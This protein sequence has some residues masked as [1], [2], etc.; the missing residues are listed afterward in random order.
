[1]V[2]QFNIGAHL[3]LFFFYLAEFHHVVSYLAQTVPVWL[4]VFSI[5]IIII[6]LIGKKSISFNRAKVAHD[7]SSCHFHFCCLKPNPGAQMMM[8]VIHSFV[9]LIVW[10]SG[11]KHTSRS[12]FLCVSCCP[13]ARLSVFHYFS[14]GSLLFLH[15]FIVVCV[16]HPSP[17]PSADRCKSFFMS[18]FPPS[19]HCF[20]HFCAPLLQDGSCNGL[21]HYAALGRD[22]IG[23]TSVNLMPCEVPQD[24]YSGVAQQVSNTGLFFCLSLFSLWRCAE[25]RK[26]YTEVDSTLEPTC[27]HLA[28]NIQVTHG[29]PQWLT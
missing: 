7:L 9:G 16:A 22:V 20:N 25:T 6:T 23:A 29:I 17:S 13:F 15:F 12:L 28:V 4:T 27:G 5:I 26:Y 2:C 18:L 8:H 10:R 14:S 24:V 21:Q 11:L 3:K 1:M 19:N